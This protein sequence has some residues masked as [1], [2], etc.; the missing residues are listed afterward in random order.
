M[1]PPAL[2]V[3]SP[4][5]PSALSPPAPSVLTAASDAASLFEFGLFEEYLASSSSV[6]GAAV[7]A[8]ADVESCRLELLIDPLGELELEAAA[9]VLELEAVVDMLELEAAVDVLELE[10]EAAADVLELAA[11]EA[12]APAATSEGVWKRQYLCDARA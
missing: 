11:E 5:A 10:V 4:S 12:A 7:E 2:S 9:D 8:E 1:S 3:L 6:A